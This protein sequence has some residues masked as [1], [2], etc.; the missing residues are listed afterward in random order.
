MPDSHPLITAL[1]AALD[2]RRD[3]IA[4]LHAE[5]TDAYRLFHGT[6]EGRPGLT[7]DRYGSL[8]LTQSFHGPL[9]QADEEALEAFYLEAFP[10][11]DH[12]Y[13]D[14][15][16]A[17]SRVSNPLPPERLV[18]A[19]ALREFSELGVKYNVQARHGGQDPWLFLDLRAAR[20][21]IMAEAPEKSVLNVFAYT[22]GVGVAAAKAGARHVVN[23]DFAESSLSVGKAN[24]RLNT[25]PFRPRFVKSDAFAAMRQL[26]G[27][28][29]PKM[30]RGKHLPPFPAWTSTA[31]IWCSS[32]RPATPR[33]RS[34]WWTWSMTTLPCSS[35]PCCAPTRAARWCAATTWPRWS[36]RRG[37]ISWYAAPKRPAAKSAGWNGSSRKRTFPAATAT[38][39]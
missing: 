22:C 8:I 28:G 30:V 39:P 2:A 37:R 26:S 15:S 23:V 33:A 29:Q 19:E 6:V 16:H 32:T 18:R 27:I 25:L 5:G 3:L 11:T 38:R 31:S 13:N 20:R 34:E 9:S 35:P 10:D 36:V 4:Q 17:N 12:V 24:A 1:G 7:V 14:R 21:R